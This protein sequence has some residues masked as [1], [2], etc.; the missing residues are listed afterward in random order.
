M[1][2]IREAERERECVCVKMYEIGENE[3]QNKR[4]QIMAPYFS[5]FASNVERRIKE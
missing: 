5:S 2:G 3:V 1:N 4:Q